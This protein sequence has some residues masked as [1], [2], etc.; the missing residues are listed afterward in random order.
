MKKRTM[1]LLAMA[2]AALTAAAGPAAAAAPRAATTRVATTRVV[3][4]KWKPCKDA[5]EV[6]CG[7][8]T[9]PVDWAD[10]DGATIQIAL[11]RR[12]ATDQKHRIGSLVYDPGGPGASGVEVV[13][14]GAAK[15]FS[16]T[17][18]SRFDIVGFD[19]RGV[20]SSTAVKCPVPGVRDHLLTEKTA[21]ALF[22]GKS[23]TEKQLQTLRTAN[24]K[25]GISC[26]RLSGPVADFLDDR[27]VAR[28]IDAIRAALGDDHL[29]YYGT[30][31]GTLM[32]EQYAEL[33][34]HRVR[35]LLLDS[36]MDHSLGLRDFLVSEAQG[37]Q[38]SFEEFVAWCDRSKKCAVHKQGARKVFTHLY[39]LADRGKLQ[40]PDSREKIDATDLIG[41]TQT[42]L[43]MPQWDQLGEWYGSLLTG[44][45]GKVQQMAGFG[46]AEKTG[47]GIFCAD[48]NVQLRDATELRSLLKQS[49]AV[50]PQM[51]ISITALGAVLSCQN[52]PTPVRNPQTRLRWGNVP[53]V[54]MVNSLHDP[55]TPYPWAQ[56][57]ARQSGATLLTY[58]GW[59]HGVVGRKEA[60]P[61]VRDAATRYLLNLKV[62][63]PGT[64]CPVT[65][66]A[67]SDTTTTEP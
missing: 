54:L 37:A 10:P 8:I 50:A 17:I 59:G 39:Q 57:A 43:L 35:A 51:K 58:A 56:N 61:C 25:D 26:R 9:V 1:G 40:D 5:P 66:S 28:D 18:R 62:P 20:G 41:G 12:R 27:S 3:A 31:Y 4:P 46:K 42:F 44:Q 16:K 2:V 45:G 15:D 7:S 13:K 38:D 22:I 24:G 14:G 34:P 36:T 21:N 49:A 53:P 52:W 60:G 64:I 30:S 6:D 23:L 55:A 65:G 11:S 47:D 63:A 29:T 19:P 32:G 67:P 48:W 33:F